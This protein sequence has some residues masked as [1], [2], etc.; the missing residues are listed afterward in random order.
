MPLLLVE[1]QRSEVLYGICLLKF[2]GITVILTKQGNTTKQTATKITQEP[3]IGSLEHEDLTATLP[4]DARKFWESHPLHTA[5][6][7][8]GYVH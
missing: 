1:T 6:S 4:A 7:F 2:I 3:C 8:G 5:Y